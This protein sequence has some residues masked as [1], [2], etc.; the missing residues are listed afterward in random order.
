MTPLSTLARE[1]AVIL[2]V[3]DEPENFRVLGDLLP[4]I[5]KDSLNYARIIV[6]NGQNLLALVNDLLDISRIENDF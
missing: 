3:D 1:N 6:E 2:I 5:S 4:E